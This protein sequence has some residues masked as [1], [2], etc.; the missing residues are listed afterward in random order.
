MWEKLSTTEL[1]QKHLANISLQS[2]LQKIILAE[3][4]LTTSCW[5]K[6]NLF[7]S[8]SAVFKIRIFTLYLLLVSST[9]A[10]VLC[11]GEHAD[12]LHVHLAVWF[13]YGPKPRAC[14]Y[15]NMYCWRTKTLIQIS[16]LKCL[17]FNGHWI[18]IS[19]ASVTTFQKVELLLNYWELCGSV[20][21]Q[22]LFFWTTLDKLPEW[23]M[24]DTSNGRP[25]LHTDLISLKHSYWAFSL[26]R[27]CSNFPV[28]IP[29][30]AQN[31]LLNQTGSRCPALRF[32]WQG[33]RG[34]PQGGWLWLWH[35]LPCVTAA[36]T[37]SRLT[38]APA[39]SHATWQ[40]LWQPS[41]NWQNS[42]ELQ[43]D[44]VLSRLHLQ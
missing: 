6:R 44:P 7:V 3:P 39:L 27:F 37:L 19:A 29:N 31:N 23:S 36:H 10:S 32:A 4:E 43:P 24:E 12:I 5:Y 9:S 18:W 34:W 1:P 15:K 20:W 8:R 11:S 38:E 35:P 13:E 40:H 42:P 41:D 33:H 21:K 30:P 17:L 28:Y 16:G 2:I 25:A 14:F 26:V 22:I